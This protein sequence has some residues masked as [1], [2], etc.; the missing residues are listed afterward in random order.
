MNRKTASLAIALIGAAVAS[1]DASAALFRAYLSGS[2]N[3]GN[4]CTLQ[5]PCRLLPAALTAI[6]DGGEIWIMDSANFNTGNVAITKSVSILAVPGAFGSIIGINGTDA[7]TIATAGVKV[8]LRN[9]KIL[10]FV[11]GVGGLNGIHMT[12]GASLKL[13]GCE[14]GGFSAVTAFPGYSAIK[15][16]APAKV[17]I[18]D[19][20]V[21]DSYNGIHLDN[22]A[23]AEISRSR[24]VGNTRNGVWAYPTVASTVTVAV[25]D[26]LSSNNQF[27]FAVSGNSTQVAKMNI[28][29]SSATNNTDSGFVVDGNGTLGAALLVASGSVASGNNIGFRAYAGRVVVSG[30]SATGNNVGFQQDDIFGAFHSLV[31]NTVTGNV[32]DT[33]GV[34]Q[35][36]VPK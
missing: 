21:R 9:V 7:I 33:I 36:Q 25:S 3:D 4:P 26:T 22:G 11:A 30:S 1:A 6:S 34:I 28:T 5:L 20:I 12:D 16:A 10:N 27:G 15:V 19:T 29:R 24:I 18:V 14:V 23:T 35:T 8:A 2:G 13:E 17:T 32:T 31:D